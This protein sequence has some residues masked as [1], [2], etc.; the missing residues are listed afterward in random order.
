MACV[1]AHLLSLT[2]VLFF[3]SLPL[4]PQLLSVSLFVFLVALKMQ[5][6][7][8]RKKAAHSTM[9]RS[10]LTH[11]HMISIVMSLNVAW[12]RTVRDVMVFVSSLTSVAGESVA[13][14]C[15]VTADVSN[16]EI[17]YAALI[18]SSVMPLGGMVLTYVFWFW[19]A[20]TSK[21]FSCGRKLEKVPF[22]PKRS[23]FSS[24]ELSEH[25]PVVTSRKGKRLHST[26]DGWIISNVLLIYA[27][28]PSIVK[29]GFQMLQPLS[30]CRRTMW[31]MD[32]SVE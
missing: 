9:K 3:L 29:M 5:T 32:R 10:L 20:P 17:F 26:R 18:A 13:V 27:L 21:W 22:C 8:N 23:P 24:K 6:T 25:R 4:S 19:L 7:S 12:P 15:S 28:Y 14:Q 11:V 31:A 1:L 2:L 30:I 16:G